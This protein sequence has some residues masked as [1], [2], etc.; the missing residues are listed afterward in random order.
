MGWIESD[1]EKPHMDFL[2]KAIEEGKKKNL[3]HKN[4][5]VG[6]LTNS[7]EYFFSIL[8]FLIIAHN[9]IKGVLHRVL[10]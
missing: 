9:W 4:E 7:F 5:L 2:W 1:L 3:S 10:G 6:H 8:L